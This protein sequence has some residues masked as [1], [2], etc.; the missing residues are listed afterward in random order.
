[1]RNLP[2]NEVYII[3]NNV[4]KVYDVIPYTDINILIEGLQGIDTSNVFQGSLL[5]LGSSYGIVNIGTYNIIPFNLYSDNYS[6]L[7]KQGILIITPA[8][9]YIIVRSFRY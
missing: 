6:I 5:N 1:M 2:K 9:L 7:Y 4:T 3:A 8:P